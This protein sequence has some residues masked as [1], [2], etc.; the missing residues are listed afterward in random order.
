[1][2]AQIAQAAGRDAEAESE[3]LRE[4]VAAL[5]LEAASALEDARE[6]AAVAAREVESSSNLHANLEA[7]LEAQLAVATSQLAEVASEAAAN[8]E[9]AAAGATCSVI[10]LTPTLTPTCRRCCS[11]GDQ[12]NPI[13]DAHVRP[14]PLAQCSA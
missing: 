7:Q 11:L 14:V 5:Q 10:T 4:R 2:W 8:A 12:P 3:S 9:R 6:K 1:M 13:P